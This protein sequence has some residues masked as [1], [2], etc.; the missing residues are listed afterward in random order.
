M[1]SSRI[2]SSFF[3]SLFNLQNVLLIHPDTGVRERNSTAHVR[4]HDA[5]VMSHD[6]KDLR[7]LAPK[8]AAGLLSQDLQTF[9]I[10]ESIEIIDIPIQIYLDK[11]F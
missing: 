8:I 1:Y 2:I 3:P 11:A 9:G 6:T 4:G 5:I 10:L 7:Q